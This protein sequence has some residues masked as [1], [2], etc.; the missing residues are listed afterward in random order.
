[1]DKS[2]LAHGTGAVLTT[3][4]AYAAWTTPTL[5][6]ADPSVVVLD[7]KPQQLRSI[8]WHDKDYDV[9][10]ERDG[11]GSRVTTRRH[12]PQTPPQSF[13]GTA[14]AT[15][16]FNRLAPLHA[17]RDMGAQ[18][19]N[20]LKSFG[21]DDSKTTL[22]LQAGDS[23]HVLKIG[24]ATF[25]NGDLYA[26][27]PEGNV[28]LLRS[29]AVATLNHGAL[30]LQDRDFLSLPA[31]RCDRAVISAHGATRE[32][33]QRFGNDIHKMYFA[34]A[35]NPDAKLTKATTWLE[36]AMRLRVIDVSHNAAPVGDAAVSVEFFKDKQSIAKLQ[37]W[38]SEEQKVVAVSSRFAAPVTL[39]KSSVDT[40]LQDVSA[41]LSEGSAG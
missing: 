12:D 17:P 34:D 5:A 6:D 16:L 11:E 4:I 36:K 8:G 15:D 31:G 22:T 21:L 7:V 14:Q 29:S 9:T 33:V 23:N 19:A 30:A 41:V 38:P 26:A 18:D 1:M 20:H 28:Y 40:L 32:V 2:L 27:T 24:N 3:L 25:G 37:L 39:S 13:P 35:V 10:V